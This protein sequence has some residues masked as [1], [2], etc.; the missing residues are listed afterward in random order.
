MPRLPG[1]RQ[2]R[3]GMRLRV[4]RIA[5]RRVR[6]RKPS[7]QMGLIGPHQALMAAVGYSRPLWATPRLRAATSAQDGRWPA[8]IQLVLSR[9]GGRGE[10]A[11]PTSSLR[12]Q[13][14][15]LYGKSVRILVTAHPPDPLCT[16]SQRFPLERTWPAVVVC[17]EVPPKK[18]ITK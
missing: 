6:S 10:S 1:S 15:D 12:R 17:Q 18:K 16:S 7:R 9:G 14:Q 8:P 13:R 3:A 2:G 4:G 11:G 5:A